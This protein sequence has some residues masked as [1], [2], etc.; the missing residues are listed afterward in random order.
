M[1]TTHM[2]KSCNQPS[3]MCS[4]AYVKPLLADTLVRHRGEGPVALE[5][6]A[7]RGQGGRCRAWACAG[8]GLGL[9]N[10]GTCCALQWTG[11]WAAP[12][13]RVYCSIG[14]TQAHGLCSVCEAN[15]G[16]REPGKPCMHVGGGVCGRRR[17]KWQWEL[18]GHHVA[19]DAARSRKV[20]G[21]S[22]RSGSHA[23]V[24]CAGQH[25][26]CPRYCSLWRKS[27]P[28]QAPPT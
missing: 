16:E 11:G 28:G 24:A 9:S 21:N 14:C 4:W 18:S 22:A 15:G 23:T 13:Y 19:C 25:A 12:M 10:R 26:C 3:P 2:L 27:T 17:A 8:V 5:R 6:T 1:A 20:C 7:A